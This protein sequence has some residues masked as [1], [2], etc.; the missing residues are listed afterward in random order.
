LG[1]GVI[2]EPS[3]G[4]N[5]SSQGDVSICKEVLKSVY[6]TLFINRF[7]QPVKLFKDSLWGYFPFNQEVRYKV[8]DDFY[9]HGNP[10]K[11]FTRF[12]LP[13][14]QKG[15]LDRNGNEYTDE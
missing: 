13:N 12:E 11:Y 7:N 4:I 1:D 6:D 14:G 10:Y 5:I 3:E 8:L 9:T 15:W 2:T